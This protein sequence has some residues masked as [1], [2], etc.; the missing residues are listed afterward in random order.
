MQDNLDEGVPPWRMAN[1]SQRGKAL[2]ID[3]ERVV[4]DERMFNNYFSDISTYGPIHFRRW[5][6]MRRSLFLTIMER[7]C[8]CDRYFVQRLDVCG[9]AGFFS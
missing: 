8:A 7:V 3:R 6:R 4:M 5:Y 2:N 1:G 9:L